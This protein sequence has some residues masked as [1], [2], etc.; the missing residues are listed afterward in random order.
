MKFWTEADKLRDKLNLHARGELYSNY[1]LMPI[2]WFRVGGCAEILF[3]P[4]DEEL[5]LKDIVERLLGKINKDLAHRNYSTIYHPT[6]SRF[7]STGDSIVRILNSINKIGFLGDKK[8]QISLQ[9]KI[10]EEK[11]IAVNINSGGPWMREIEKRLKKAGFRVL[12]ASSVNDAIEVSG[13]KIIKY[14]EASAR[15][16]LRVDAQAPTGLMYRCFG[17]GY[18]FDYIHADLIDLQSNFQT[19]PQT[20]TNPT[21]TKSNTNLFRTKKG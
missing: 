16:F 5:Q 1:S 4:K 18:N 9:K 6:Y 15:Y 21:P 2:S 17:G 7:F 19:L 3:V 13:K 8:N 11:V 14:N 20:N 12:R 10:S